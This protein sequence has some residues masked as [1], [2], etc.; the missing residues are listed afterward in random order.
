MIEWGNTQADPDTFRAA[1]GRVVGSV[2]V[3]TTR[4]DDRPWGMTVSAFSGVCLEPPTVLVCVDHR[5][6]TAADIR[7]ESRFAVNLLSQDQV[8][9]SRLCSRVGT[10]KF[11]DD[12]VVAGGELPDG[13]TSPVL[14]D[15]LV[16]FDCEVA[17]ARP[18]GSHFVVFGR[19]RVVLAPRSRCPLLFG[20]GRYQR[21][22]DIEEVP[23]M[24]EAG[25]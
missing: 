16:T 15:S 17:E 19:V 3:V 23:A 22:V 25:T 4:H 9:V 1:M 14:R 12:H 7:R 18:M 5:S 20:Q 2:T 24:T 8:A 10:V 21:S 6:V 13:V 11:V